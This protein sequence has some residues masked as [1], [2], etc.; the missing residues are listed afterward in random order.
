MPKKRDPKTERSYDRSNAKK[1]KDGMYDADTGKKYDIAVLDGDS[2]QMRRRAP[3]VKEGMK[4]LQAKTEE[5][6][7]DK[8]VKKRIR[9]ARMH[10]HKELAAIVLATGGTRKQASRKSGVSLRQIQKYWESSDFRDRVAELQELL[11]NRVRGKVIKEINRRTDPALIKKMELLDL[12]RV[13]DRFGLGRGKDSAINVNT[14]IH[15]YESTFNEVFL[16][17][18]SD[19]EELDSDGEEEGEDFPAFEPTSLALSGGDSPVDG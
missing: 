17:S 5:E 18:G 13:G 12:L 8:N 1:I 14:E 10:A 11:G 3:V 6:L 7:V 2:S 16:N 4:I 15:N 9:Y 19:N